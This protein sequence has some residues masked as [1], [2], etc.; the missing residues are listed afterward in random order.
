MSLKLLLPAF[1]YVFSQNVLLVFNWHH[2]SSQKNLIFLPLR[3]KQVTISGEWF[4][5]FNECCF[6]SDF[7]FFQGRVS[8]ITCSAVPPQ[9]VQC[10]L[11]IR[12]G[13]HLVIAFVIRER[14]NTQMKWCSIIERLISL[15]RD[16]HKEQ[17]QFHLFL[18]RYLAVAH[19]LFEHFVLVC[20]GITRGL[21]WHLFSSLPPDNQEVGSG[22]PK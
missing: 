8:V 15:N 14:K 18:S 11:I 7:T 5:C 1:T 10:P 22:Y 21:S 20:Y 6:D 12:L 4:H 17:L 9:C 13:E 3:I 16:R 2:Y 19:S